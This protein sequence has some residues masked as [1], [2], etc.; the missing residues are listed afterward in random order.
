[1][2]I[3]YE[4]LLLCREMDIRH[5]LLVNTLCMSRIFFTIYHLKL[6]IL[7][8]NYVAE[9]PPIW[10][11]FR[12]SYVLSLS[13]YHVHT[14]FQELIKIVLKVVALIA[15]IVA[16]IED[17]FNGY[18]IHITDFSQCVYTSLSLENVACVNTSCYINIPPKTCYCCTIYSNTS[19][20][21]MRYSDVANCEI[22][23][24]ILRPVLFSVGGLGLFAIAIIAFSIQSSFVYVAAKQVKKA[25]GVKQAKD[26]KYILYNRVLEN[27][28]TLVDILYNRSS[29]Q[30]LVKK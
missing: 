26:K 23:H 12:R 19:C 27:L 10:V 13:L 21:A 14:S 7:C 17:F 24:T 5:W 8:N 1:M 16:V 30:S 9:A 22:L 20:S 29:V 6:S 11:E 2:L 3:L 4:L 25:Y 28:L 18:N 15:C